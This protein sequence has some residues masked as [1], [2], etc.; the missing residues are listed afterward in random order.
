MTA[1]AARLTAAGLRAPRF[2]GAH[3]GL[4]LPAVADAL[5]AG[6]GAEDAGAR[7]TLGLEPKERA[8]VVLVDG[9]GRGNLAE[10][11]GHAP[12]LRARLAERPAGIVT[13]FPTTTASA[14]GLFGTG[15]SG[16]RTGL[17]GY[18]ARNP[19]TGGLGNFV[20]WEGTPPPEEWQREPSL[21][22]ELESRGVRVT[23]VGPR[24]FAG[25][26]LTSA[27]FRGGAYVPVE[28][29]AA[30][31]DAALDALRTPGLVY[32]YWGELDKIGHQLGWRSA[33][34]GAALETLDAELARL[35]RSLPRGTNL[36]VTADHGMVDVDLS[37]RFDLADHPALAAD[38]ALLGG[39]P[40]A[41]HVY[42]REGVDGEGV[43]ARWRT[44]LAG[45]AVVAT[46]SEVVDDGWFGEVVSRVLPT[47]GDLV[48]VA[49]DRATVVDSASATPGLLAM[50]GVH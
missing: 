46:R 39:E 48:V 32:L 42:V 12:F 27:V 49:R 50:V 24:R 23:S 16:G 14:L 20:R 29:L 8:V 30:R 13:G 1:L 31:V 25:S 18:A 4:V 36:V 38:V 44:E 35:A 3:L 15:R 45:H 17:V 9:L 33:Q 40:R 43:A 10:L 22:G 6:S 11:A 21:L 28:G 47:V 19:A 2:D 7:R 41:V 34:W 37:R 5:G 26:G